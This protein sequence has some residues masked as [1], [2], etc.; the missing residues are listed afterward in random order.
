MKDIRLDITAEHLVIVKELL[1]RH[2]PG[3]AVWAYG[4]RV[5]GKSKTHSDLDIVVF[6]TDTKEINELKDAFSESDLPFQVDVLDWGKIPDSFKKN[7][8]EMYVVV[9]ERALNIYT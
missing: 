4:S 2:V 5:T 8:M 7:I 6:E 9:Q 1:C 3:K